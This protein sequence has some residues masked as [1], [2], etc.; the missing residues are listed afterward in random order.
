MAALFPSFTAPLLIRAIQEGSA[1]AQRALLPR[2]TLTERRNEPVV[3]AVC[4]RN[5]PRL[6]PHVDCKSVTGAR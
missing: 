1:R 6:L 4:R 3:K 2:V 5:S